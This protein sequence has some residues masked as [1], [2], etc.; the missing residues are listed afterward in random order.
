VRVSI[1]SDSSIPRDLKVPRQVRK[2]VKKNGNW[3]DISYS[4]PILNPVETEPVLH[5]YSTPT[6]TTRGST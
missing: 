2:E 6:A 5:H 4:W 1:R 3:G